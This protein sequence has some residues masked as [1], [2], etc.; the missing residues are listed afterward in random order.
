MLTVD[1]I[2]DKYLPTF[3][4]D[5]ARIRNIKSQLRQQLK[6][7]INNLINDQERKKRAEKPATKATR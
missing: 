3:N 5:C 1:Q 4:S 2:A 6:N 7:D